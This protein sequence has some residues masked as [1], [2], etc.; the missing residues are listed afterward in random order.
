MVNTR[1]YFDPLLQ[2][3]NSAIEEHFMDER[4]R[5]M[6]QVVTEP[7]QV[8]TAFVAAPPW[9]PEARKFATK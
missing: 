4:H 3:L 9:S 8:E 2:Q 6:W 5:E 1:R 7:E